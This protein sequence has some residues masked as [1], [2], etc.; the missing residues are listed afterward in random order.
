[1]SPE[2]PAAWR[3][4]DPDPFREA[5]GYLIRCSRKRQRQI[6]MDHHRIEVDIKQK[7]YQHE[8]FIL[9]S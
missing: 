9:I 1:M 6:V 2:D 8:L 3:I 4:N 7:I 5:S